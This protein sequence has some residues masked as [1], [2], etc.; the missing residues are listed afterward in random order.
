MDEGFGEKCGSVGGSLSEA[1]PNL[2]RQER[3]TQCTV[4]AQC[5]CSHLNMLLTAVQSLVNMCQ[6]SLQVLLK[7][8]SAVVLECFCE[9]KGSEFV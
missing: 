8:L 9:G 4:Y 1:H 6:F 7:Y 3:C 5:S 2:T